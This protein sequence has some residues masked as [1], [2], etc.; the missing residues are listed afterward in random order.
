[1]PSFLTRRVGR[2]GGGMGWFVLAA[3]V[4]LALPIVFS[5]GGAFFADGRLSLRNFA[6]LAGDGARLWSLGSNT[7][8]VAAGA[9]TVAL[10]LGVPLGTLVFR[11]DLPGRGKKRILNHC[12]LW[13]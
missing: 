9:V 12:F 10:G 4:V 11:T 3:A 8:T 7:T 13:T 6:A 5:L 1:M 2:T